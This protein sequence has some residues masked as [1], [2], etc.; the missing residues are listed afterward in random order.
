MKMRSDPRSDEASV[1]C[2]ICGR[3]TTMTGTKRCDACWEL[4]Q[5]ILAAPAIAAKILARVR[6]RRKL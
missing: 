6:A 3:L 5:R 4:E 2:E 1:P